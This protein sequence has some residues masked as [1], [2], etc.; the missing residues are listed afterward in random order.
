MSKAVLLTNHYSPH[1]NIVS[2]F[3]AAAGLGDHVEEKLV[4][5][6]KKEHKEPAYLAVNPVGQIAALQ[7]GAVNVFESD[8]IIRYLALKHKSPLLPFSDPAKFAL[9]DSVQTHIRQRAWD[10]GTSLVFQVAFLKPF[11]GKDPDP[12]VVEEKVAALDKALDF[13]GNTFFKHGG[14]WLVGFLSTADTTLATLLEHTKKF[15]KYEPKNERILAFRA[16][17]EAQPF[18][19]QSHYA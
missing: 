2:D 6:A 5:F 4:D 12:K 9:V 3:V 18:F 17:W 11:Y 16:H 15:A 13:I 1:G 7:D 19:K 14:P 8:A 10:H